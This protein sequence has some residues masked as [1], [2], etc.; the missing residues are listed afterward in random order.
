MLKKI[1]LSMLLTMGSL[2]FADS[3]S[4]GASFGDT[5]FALNI[6]DINTAAKVSTKDFYADVCLEFGT[7]QTAIKAATDSGMEPAEVYLALGFA[8]ASG[9]PLTDVVSVW[10]KKKTKDWSEIGKDLKVDPG[11]AKFKK[12]KEKAKDRKG[13]MKHK[14]HEGMGHGKGNKKNK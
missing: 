6:S 14:N 10:K 8:E 4:L 9:K 11:S 1:S 5:D 3:F 13:K 12:F 2:L 7:T